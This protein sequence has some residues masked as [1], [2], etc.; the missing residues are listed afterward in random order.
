MLF[1]VAGTEITKGKRLSLIPSLLSYT[2]TKAVFSYMKQTADHLLHKSF[3]H[4][5]ASMLNEPNDRDKTHR[6]NH[7]L[8]WRTNWR[9]RWTAAA[10]RYG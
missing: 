10:G 2:T 5:Y 4:F 3:K 9:G 8:L 7:G 6:I 1:G